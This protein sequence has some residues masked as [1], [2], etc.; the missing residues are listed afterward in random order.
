MPNRYAAAESSAIVVDPE[1]CLTHYYMKAF[2]QIVV[3]RSG[4]TTFIYCTHD[5]GLYADYAAN[6]FCNM[7]THR[8]ADVFSSPAWYDCPGLNPDAARFTKA[9]LLLMAW[10]A[11]PCIAS[12]AFMLGAGSVVW[13]MRMD[14]LAQT[15]LFPVGGFQRTILVLGMGLAA[16][17]FSVPWMLQWLGTVTWLGIALFVKGIFGLNVFC[18]LGVGT[19]DF[20]KPFKPLGRRIRARMGGR[21]RVGDFDDDSLERERGVDPSLWEEEFESKIMQPYKPTE[22]LVIEDLRDE[23]KIITRSN[24]F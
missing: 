11:L 5:A 22:V 13:R 10:I 3:P 9:V 24:T 12:V 20:W 8:P 7:K 2:F 6:G 18:N 15:K 4:N 14:T 17:L 1:A 19:F 16:A 23:K 21:E